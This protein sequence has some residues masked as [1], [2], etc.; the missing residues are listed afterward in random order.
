MVDKFSGMIEISSIGGKR[1]FMVEMLSA[2]NGK[3]S[4][5]ADISRSYHP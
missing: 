4:V 3:T 1:M 2:M 5:M